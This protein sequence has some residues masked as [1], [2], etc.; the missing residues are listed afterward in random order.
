MVKIIT[1][2]LIVSS[3][4]IGTYRVSWYGGKHHGRITKSG[5]VFDKNKLTCAASN[6]YKI[7]DKLRVTNVK[8]Q[9]SVDVLVNDRGNFTGLGRTLDLSEGAFRKIADLQQGVADVIITKLN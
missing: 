1:T 4:Q 7:G 6:K 5:V 9:K 8:N 2:L 3:L